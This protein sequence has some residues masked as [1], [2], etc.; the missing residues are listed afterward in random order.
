MENQPEFGSLYELLEYVIKHTAGGKVLMETI[1]IKPPCP[2]C[3]WTLTDMAKQARL[4][5]GGCYEHFKEELMRV[6]IHAH[7]AIRH[8][9]KHPKHKGPVSFSLE[10]LQTQLTQAV[11]E[12]RYEDAS[13]IKK[14]ILNYKN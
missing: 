11:K 9:G 10:K 2:S 7:K 12:E 8:T 5:C 14:M 6:L 3:G 1:P 4:G 13:E